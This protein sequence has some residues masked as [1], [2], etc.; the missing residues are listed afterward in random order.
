[1]LFT[2]S[3]PVLIR[4]LWQLKTVVFLHWFQICAVLLIT[5]KYGAFLS[6]ATSLGWL[7]L[8]V[9]SA[10]AY[11]AWVKIT[12]VKSFVSKYLLRSRENEK[13]LKLY[14]TWACT[15]K[16]FTVDI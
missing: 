6:W 5:N 14:F 12:V 13:I 10:L 11:H 16:P 7:W 8:T 1:M 2:F 4:H 15:V 9:T 3:T